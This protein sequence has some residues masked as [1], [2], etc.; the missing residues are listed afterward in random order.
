MITAQNTDIQFQA[1]H[2]G[3]TMVLKW[4]PMRA[5]LWDS[6]NTIGYTIERFQLDESGNVMPNTGE[7][8]GNGVEQI[9]PRDSFW[10]AEH[11][12][13]YDGYLGAMGSLL[14][15][16]EH[17]YSDDAYDSRETRYNFLVY[18]ST[19]DD[20]IAADVLG[21]AIPDTTMVDGLLYKYILYAEADGQRV[22]EA[23]VTMDS[24]SGEWINDI[25][26]Y[27]FEWEFLGGQS[28]TEMSGRLAQGK[29]DQLAINARGYG[30]SIIIR[31]APNNAVLW[32]KINK[33]GYELFRYT[34]EDNTMRVDSFGVFLPWPEDWLDA[35]ITDTAAI[36][37]ANALY[38]EIP[39][40]VSVLEKITLSENQFSLALLAAEQSAL[41]AT[42]LGLRFVDYDVEEGKT[43]NYFVRTPASDEPTTTDFVE[44]K[45]EFVPDPPPVLFESESLDG[46]VKL[47][48][49]KNQ[50]SRKFTFFNV[51]RSDDGGKTFYRLNDKPLFFTEDPDNPMEELSYVDSVEANY[52]PYTYQ[53]KGI[54]SFTE[55][56]LPATCT[57]MGIDLTAPTTP[58]L[59]YGELREDNFYI[60]LKWQ[61][62]QIEEDLAGFKIQLKKEDSDDE[63]ED[64]EIDLLPITTF[65]YTYSEPVRVDRSYYFRIVAVDTA[66]N[67]APSWPRFVNIPD[68]VP[69]APP[70]NL[71][72]FIDT[73]GIAHIAW[74][75]GTEADLLGYRIFFAND[76]THEFSQKTV[77]SIDI[78][79]FQDT[80]DLVTLTEK[81]YY[82]VVAED[83]RFNKSEFSA[84]LELIKPDIIPPTTPDFTDSE[85]TGNGVELNWTPSS[86]ADVVAYEIYRREIDSIDYQLI[87]SVSDSIQEYRFFDST[88]V[89]EVN[90]QYSCRARDDAGNYSDYAFPEMGRRYFEPQSLIV[91]NLEVRY[92]E[93]TKL[94]EIGWEFKELPA[95]FLADIPY[96]FFL[97]REVGTEG[98]GKYKQLTANE[99]FFEDENLE[100]EGVYKYAV[101]VVYENGK[102]GVVSEPV[103]ITY[104][105]E[106]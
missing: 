44:I 86:S 23:E 99:L 82:R 72:G 1:S 88:G 80:L 17:Q 74:D 40:G 24:E 100:T 75:Q 22:I 26:D 90:Y 8:F 53:L 3:G 25:G 59:T 18:E 51:E 35:S 12:D 48:W 34:R 36:V 29:F 101:K 61:T 97:Y 85:I 14:Y 49:E 55:E 78:N 45:N 47:T 21:L 43:Y 94:I 98:M 68:D 6:L 10:F 30:D 56:S 63:F 93:T 60:E 105:A 5:S 46:V 58:S 76:S 57:G 41:A 67:E 96:Y 103:E 102:T 79:Y 2:Y 52:I 7:L 38:G 28:L 15:D 31:W 71:E 106:E 66:G 27:E 64:L 81:I 33:E 9:M 20:N 83:Y 104:A 37:A 32:N 92:N 89:Y 19:F 84:I 50:N 69:P 77:S 13:D 4:T 16:P 73:F 39:P 70:L 95:A 65:E 62:D 42:I 87:G 54:N 91:Q 11:A